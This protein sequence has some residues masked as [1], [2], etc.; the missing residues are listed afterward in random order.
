MDC[1]DVKETRLR[2]EPLPPGAARHVE[3]C[4]VCSLP[5]HTEAATP[6]PSPG[7]FAELETEIA[8]DRGTVAWLRSRP[9]RVRVALA[10]A[11]VAV[12]SG[13]TLLFMPRTAF[14]PM[15]VH[16]VLLETSVLSVLLLSLVRLGLRPLQSPLLRRGALR[17]ALG[18]AL[19]VPALFAVLPTPEAERVELPPGISPALSAGVCFS[20]GMMTALLLLL[21]LRI[22]DRR[23]RGSRVPSLLAAAAGGLAG[24]LALELHCPSTSVSHLLVSHATVGF[25]LVAAVRLVLSGRET[26]TE[27]A[28]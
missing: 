27:A 19:A 10:A 14:A 15:P 7:L 11:L 22:L 12:V 1:V 28:P 21:A 18:A 9:T 2:G 4:P 8:S 23:Q 17:A 5:P 3:T 13:L 6:P 24:N 25:V 20:F 26:A 16:R